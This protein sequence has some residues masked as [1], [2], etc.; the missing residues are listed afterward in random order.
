MI[1]HETRFGLIAAGGLT[2]A[3]LVGIGTWLALRHLDSVGVA[4]RHPGTGAKTYS[5]TIAENLRVTRHGVRGVDFIKCGVCRLEKRKKG[6]LTLG[7]MN[8]LVLE[9]L[10]VVIPPEGVGGSGKAGAA[11]GTDDVAD[12]VSRLGISGGFLASRGMPAKFSGL[13]VSHLTVDRLAE[14]EVRQAVFRATSANAVRG[15]LA[16]S[17]CE[18]AMPSGEMTRVG[19]AMLAKRGHRLCLSWAGGER[20]LN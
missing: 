15:G 6:F 18:V 4:E 17:G 1:C 13:R 9:D 14:G 8:V 3:V 12:I 16:L 7:G 2:L 19:K 5:R 11:D 20:F 10:S